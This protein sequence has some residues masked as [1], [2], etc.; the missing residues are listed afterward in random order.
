M[1]RKANHL[2]DKLHFRRRHSG[3]LVLFSYRQHGDVCVHQ[4]VCLHHMLR[5]RRRRL[6]GDHDHGTDVLRQSRRAEEVRRVLQEGQSRSLISLLFFNILR[7]G[8]AK[9]SWCP[10]AKMCFHSDLN[11]K[12]EKSIRF[13]H[14]TCE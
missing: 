3:I 10:V 13:L 8:C 7:E 14:L 6:G 11:H 1:S 5:L 4:V 2:P 12:N 9:C